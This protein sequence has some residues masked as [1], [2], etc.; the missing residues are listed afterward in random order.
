MRAFF[1]IDLSISKFSRKLSRRD[2]ER[3]F[4][5]RIALAENDETDIVRKEPVEQWHENV[6]TFFAHDPRHHS[7]HRSARFGFQSQTI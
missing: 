3:R 6:E 7:K 5:G 1:I 2:R 4:I